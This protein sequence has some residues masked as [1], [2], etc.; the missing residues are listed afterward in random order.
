MRIGQRKA[1]IQEHGLGRK[2]AAP[3]SAPAKSCVILARAAVSKTT[4]PD[5]A[6]KLAANASV[7]PPSRLLALDLGAR[8]IGVAVSDELRL[9]VR[10]LPA[11]RRSSWKQLLR[12]IKN[13]REQFDARGVVIGLPLRLDGTEGDAAHEARRIARNIELSLDVP[14]YLQDE[15]LT[16]REAENELRAERI[17]EEELKARVDSAAAVIILRDFLAHG[18]SSGN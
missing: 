10:P 5:R 1:M 16:S 3:F 13:L 11:L 18:S 2:K 15:R 6:N 12:E 8:R 7:V 4:L 9:T 14:V 17:T